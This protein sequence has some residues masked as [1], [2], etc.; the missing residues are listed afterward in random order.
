[1]A[2]QSDKI[3]ALEQGQTALHQG[4][5]CQGEGNSQLTYFRSTSTRLVELITDTRHQI[6][7]RST[8]LSTPVSWVSTFI[9]DEVLEEDVNIKH[10][11]SANKLAL[12]MDACFFGDSTIDAVHDPQLLD[13]FEKL[14][15]LTATAA[16]ALVQ[17]GW[18]IHPTRAASSQHGL[19][20][21]NMSKTGPD[22]ASYRYL[23]THI[24]TVTADSELEIPEGFD[25]IRTIVLSWMQSDE[26][27]IGCNQEPEYA[28]AVVAW[29]T[30]TPSA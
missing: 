14:Y 1:M 5:N 18:S 30:K 22:F 3:N 20:C 21:S 8:R 7:E 19:C 29:R 28:T 10:N 17:R 12:D 24:A 2:E 4:Q 27:M 23:L 16:F 15:G 26:K 6:S 11:H 25:K 13:G 9:R